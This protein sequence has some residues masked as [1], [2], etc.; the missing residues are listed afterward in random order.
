[1]ILQGCWCHLLRAFYSC[2]DSEGVSAR[3]VFPVQAVQQVRWT[4]T[5]AL[6]ALGR[7][8]PCTSAWECLPILSVEGTVR[9]G[10]VTGSSEVC[11]LLCVL[12]LNYC[13]QALKLQ[14]LSVCVL[15][16]PRVW[17]QGVHLSSTKYIAWFI[18]AYAKYML[19]ESLIPSLPPPWQRDGGMPRRGSQYWFV[20]IVS[21][22][23]CP[24]CFGWCFNSEPGVRVFVFF[25]SSLLL[26][27]Y[28][29]TSIL[30][31]F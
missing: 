24:Y 5:T 1:M 30:G 14:L 26:S 19:K 18:K 15:R 16:R 9:A 6:P 7:A 8:G 3:P 20:H 12:L 25:F 31:P 4:N 17:R 21:V 27:P 2:S 29:F 11:V 28:A 23:V 22:L 13:T 10:I